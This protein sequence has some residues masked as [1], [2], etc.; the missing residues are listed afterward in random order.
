[1]ISTIQQSY[2]EVARFM[3]LRNSKDATTLDYTGLLDDYA[4]GFQNKFVGTLVGSGDGYLNFRNLLSSGFTNDYNENINFP[5]YNPYALTKC[6]SIENEDEIV[7]R[8]GITFDCYISDLSYIFDY[9]LLTVTNN[10]FLQCDCNVTNT[11]LDAC[12]LIKTKL[13]SGIFIEK[14]ERS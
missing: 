6:Q 7:A 1:M 12:N 13:A 11:I 5:V 8:Q 9:N 3:A 2:Q 4:G 10:T 14:I